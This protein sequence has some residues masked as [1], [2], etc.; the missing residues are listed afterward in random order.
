M[1]TLRSGSSQEADGVAAGPE[2][3]E[4]LLF[5][6]RPRL[7]RY[8]A[9]MTGSAVDGEDVVQ[10]ALA[11]A[12]VALPEAGPIVRPEAWL[13]RIA[14]NA[15]LDFLRRRARA[16]AGRSEEDPEMVAD[17]E[18]DVSRRAAAAASLHTFMRLSVSERSTV[19]LA[20]VLDYS[21][22]E[23]ADVLD[24]SIPSVKA[25]LHRGRSRLRALAQEPDDRPT[26]R[27][28]EKERSLLS[29]YVERFNA[30][31]FEAIRDMLAA[32]VRLDLVARTRMSGRS[33]VGTYLGNYSR[34]HDWRFVAGFVDGR[35]AAIAC[36]PGTFPGRP[37]YF[38]V[39]D[40]REK[41]ILGIRDFRYARYACES[42]EIVA[43]DR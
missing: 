15:A 41:E 38:V 22:R 30:R 16:E 7:H 27:M 40:W 29:A 35:P 4:A 5:R 8:C 6:L 14:H 25:S 20:D 34:T 36:E 18:N 13:F 19:I 23:V 12:V 11:K 33:E 39:V 43:L 42:A 32:E 31:D 17:P 3:L 26:P 24:V 1:K 28:S 10:D 37:I 2:S 21:Q 9:R